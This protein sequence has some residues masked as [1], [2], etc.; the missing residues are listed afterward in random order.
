MENK[1]L[2]RVGGLL[3]EKRPPVWPGEEQ[4]LFQRL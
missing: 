4:A 2:A 3:P 1:R